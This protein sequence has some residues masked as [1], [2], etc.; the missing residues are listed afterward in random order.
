MLW[1]VKIQMKKIRLFFKEHALAFVIAAIAVISLILVIIIF[2]LASSGTSERSVTI[3]TVSGSAF[4]LKTD[5]QIPASPGTKLT[6]GDVIITSADGEVRLCTDKDTYIYI[7]PETTLYVNFTDISNTGSIIVNISQGAAICRIDSKLSRNEAFEVRTPNAVISAAG[8]VFRTEFDYYD[9]YGGYSEVKLTEVQC[10]QGEVHIQLYDNDASA[11]EQLMALGAGK[12][13]RLLTCADAARYE[14]LN[15]PTD[16]SVY[17]ET[18][19][20]TF[21]RIAAERDAGYSLSELNLAYQALLNQSSSSDTDVT[22][23]VTEPAET[24][25]AATTTVTE[26]EASTDTETEISSESEISETTEA[27]TTAAELQ[28]TVPPAETDSSAVT[29]PTTYVAYVTTASSTETTTSQAAVTETTSVA[30]EGQVPAISREESTAVTTVTAAETVV[31]T[32]TTAPQTSVKPSKTTI[33]W[34]EIIN[35]NALTTQ[36]TQAE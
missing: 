3:D 33:P 11:V 25:T 8:T 31:T 21:I 35:S 24:T 18:T 10:A 2:T 34:W 17:S 12:S 16:L 6:N 7:E 30:S 36:Q 4:I 23:P 1:S 32:E 28:T 29:S 15:S 5:G 26:T 27:E 9:E 14:Y 13:A 19:V 20:K 22:L